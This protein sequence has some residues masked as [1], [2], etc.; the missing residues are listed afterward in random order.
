MRKQMIF[1]QD[2]FDALAEEA[3][4]DLC[5]TGMKDEEI[6]QILENVLGPQFVKRHYKTSRSSNT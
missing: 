2:L 5:K 3:V 1:P 4:A 6:S